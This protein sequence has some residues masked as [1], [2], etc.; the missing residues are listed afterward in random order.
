[1]NKFAAV[2]GA[3]SGIGRACALGLLKEGWAVAL[4][5]RRA[6]ATKYLSLLRQLDPGLRLSTRVERMV[7]RHLN[8]T[9]FRLPS[10][11]E[12]HDG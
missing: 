4:L 1:M 5:G 9:F 10:D 12:V 6:D 3:G 11:P 2:T 7:L 8:E